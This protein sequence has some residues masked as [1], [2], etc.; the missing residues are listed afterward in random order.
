MSKTGPELAAQLHAIPAT[1]LYQGH[2][3]TIE[4]DPGPIRLLPQTCLNLRRE[5]RFLLTRSRYFHPGRPF[6]C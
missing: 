5:Y 6:T 3:C 2:K 1:E 4:L